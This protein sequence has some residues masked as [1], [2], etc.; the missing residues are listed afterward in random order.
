[1]RP[2]DLCMILPLPGALPVPPDAGSWWS[3]AG[4]HLDAMRLRH[5]EAGVHPGYSPD[6]R[7]ARVFFVGGPADRTTEFVGDGRWRLGPDARE[8]PLWWIVDVP[9]YRE[10]PA[11]QAWTSES[12]RIVAYR[13]VGFL[14]TGFA[15]A[16][17][18]DTD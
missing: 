1:M 7:A 16:T 8:F 5:F 14:P 6:H 18:L 10:P 4:R 9:D 3:A 13:C 12:L 17:C 11:G 15:V 2:I